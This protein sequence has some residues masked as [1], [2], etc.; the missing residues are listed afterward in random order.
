MAYS[1]ILKNNVTA[2]VNKYGESIKAAIKGSGLYFET[3]VAQK[4]IES[5]YGTTDQAKLL[6]NF[7]GI[8]YTRNFPSDVTK[9]SW[10]MYAKF[11]TPQRCFQYYVANMKSPN[12]PYVSAGVFTAQS[13]EEQLL[14]INKAGYCAD[15]DP[16]T[17][18]KQANPIIAAVRDLY[19]VGKVA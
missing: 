10:S 2:F 19:K 13:P 4:C 15:P 1:Q 17:Y 7:G 16:K 18:S 9:E 12:K 5:A 6:N 8:V 11:P 14:R 3:V